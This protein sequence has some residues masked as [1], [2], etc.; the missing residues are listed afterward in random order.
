LH[1]IRDFRNLYLAFFIPLL[2]VLL[3]GYVLSLDVE[4][5]KIVVVDHNK[6]EASRDFIRKLD[7]SAYFS[8]MAHLADSRAVIRYLDHNQASL[9]IVIPPDWTANI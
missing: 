2:L 1:L 4:D 8:V 3:F 7:A 5:V 9:G 6:T